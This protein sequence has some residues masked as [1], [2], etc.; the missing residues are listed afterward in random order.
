MVLNLFKCGLF[1]FL[2]FEINKSQSFCTGWRCDESTIAPVF[3][4]LPKNYESLF[5]PR[6]QDGASEYVQDANKTG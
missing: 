4:E 3:R 1:K 6:V 5:G 2:I